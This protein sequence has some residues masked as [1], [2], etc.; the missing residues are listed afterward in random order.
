MVVND[1]ANALLLDHASG[2]LPEPLSLAVST[3]IAINSEA[4]AKYDALN[5]VGGLMIEEI[6]LASVSDDAFA[7]VMNQLEATS[8]DNTA[9]S[10]VRETAP[11]FDSKTRAL[12]PEPL[13]AYLPKSLDD[14]GWK[15]RGGGVREYPI[16]IN[17]DGFSV[18]LLKIEPGHAIPAHTH[19][20]REYTVILDGAYEDGGMIVQMGDLVCNDDTDVHKPIADARD[21]C[22]CLAVT[23]APLRFKGP[24][25]W[26][27]NPFLRG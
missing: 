23:D 5:E 11:D 18:S 4:R 25:G 2:S 22:L 12:V 7:A 15:S 8:N 16:N 1:V 27:I 14:L 21:G 20:G 9:D 26:F 10:K 13:R 19:K 17:S 3:H 6:E 24:L